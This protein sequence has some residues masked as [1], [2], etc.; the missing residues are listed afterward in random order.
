M[1][2]V[3]LHSFFNSIL[4]TV[5]VIIWYNIIYV[6]KSNRLG[7]CYDSGH[8]NC[9][10]K[11]AD[12]LSLYG[13]KLMALHLHDNDCIEDQHRIPGEGTIDWNYVAQKIKSIGYS[14]AIS[15][16]ITNEFSNQYSGTSAQEF[17]MIANE[18]IRNLF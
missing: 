15:L 5:I 6:I 14:G 10:C 11:G 8:E 3:L 17:L 9:Y 2:H 12:L 16:E 1:F 18:R 7:F 13:D 4:L